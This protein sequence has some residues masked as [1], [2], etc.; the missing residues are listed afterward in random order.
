MHSLSDAKRWKLFSR[1]E[2]PTR[3][4]LTG[5]LGTGSGEMGER[6]K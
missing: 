1:V 2:N 6:Q 5:I 4:N 3:V